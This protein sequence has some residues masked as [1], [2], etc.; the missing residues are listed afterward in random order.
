MDYWL[1]LNKMQPAG[2]DLVQMLAVY[3]YFQML[4]LQRALSA[5]RKGEGALWCDS[6]Y[7][8][9]L[10]LQVKHCPLELL[11]WCY[12]SKFCFNAIWK[13]L[14]V[15]SLMYLWLGSQES[16]GRS[17][18]SLEKVKCWSEF[19]AR[20]KLNK[21]EWISGLMWGHVPLLWCWC[22]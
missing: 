1:P 21:A 16:T 19:W 14:E 8:Q 3:N 10:V 15:C 4:H 18:P 20:Q 12:L 11:S 9:A 22:S 13:E 17:Q 2:S 5:E 7:F 6:C